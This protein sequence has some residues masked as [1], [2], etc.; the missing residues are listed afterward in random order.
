MISAILSI[1][2]WSERDRVKTERP[3]KEFLAEAEDILESVSRALLSMEA[4]AARGGAAPDVVNSLFRS[5]HSFKGLAGVFGLNPPAELAHKLETLL[6]EMR[7]G[8]LSASR[9]VLDVLFDTTTVLGRL[10]KQAGQGQPFEDITDAVSSID[11]VLKSASAAPPDRSILEHISLDKAILQVLTEYEEH[12]LIENLQGRKNI[13]RIKANFDLSDFESRIKN[14]NGLLKKHGEIICTLPSAESGTGI[15]FTIIVGTG[16]SVES[17]S[18]LLSDP[19][20]VIE[21]VPYAIPA[22]ARQAQARGTESHALKSSS[23]TVRVDISKL[24][25]LMNIVADLHLAKNAV[26]R[27]AMDLR[28]LA[29]A[30]GYAADLNK[31]HR[32]LERKLNDLQEGILDVR[33]VPIGQIFT[34]LAQ[35]VRRYVRE[36]GKEIE[37]ELLGE[38]TELDKLMIEDLADPLMHLIRNAIDHGV[39]PAEER[40]RIG[41]PEQGLIRL[42]AYPKGNH[43]VITVEDDGRGMDPSIILAKAV[44]KGLIGKDHGLDPVL[45]TKEILDLIFLPGFS[46]SEKVTEISGRGV[47]MDVVKKNV[48]KLSGIIDIETEPGAGTR[49]VLT[50]P[51]TLAIIKALVVEAGGQVFSIPLSSVLE[52]IRATPEQV[53]TVEAREVMVIRDETVPLLRLSRVFGLPDSNSHRL[54]YVI[55]VGLAERRLGIVVD[56]LRDQQ[57]IV[58]KP[59]GKRLAN[60]AGIAGATELSIGERRVVLVLDVES[61]IDAAFKRGQMMRA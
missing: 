15:S 33:M 44:E 41:K 8:K 21:Q 61:L 40:K 7:L 29:G 48:S 49:F 27:I 30:A 54:F 2:N 10:V 58:I 5:V 55:L 56:R 6:D 9:D 37:L 12:R 18:A 50:L 36:S 35:V 52:I 22:E 45:D 11:T 47:G 1:L 13:L 46:T 43:V 17:L 26:S 19:T 25:S 53:Q 4:D 34:R 32:N 42:T 14:L 60:T 23:N 24:D 20:I 28:V 38:E 51:I 59:L 3:I 39:E 16:E 31:V 57:D